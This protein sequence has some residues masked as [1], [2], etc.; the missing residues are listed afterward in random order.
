MVEMGFTV[1]C[2]A[3]LQGGLIP[4]IHAY[5]GKNTSPALQWSHTPPDTCSFVLIMED[6][7]AADGTVTH[8][9]LF[10]IPGAA[11]GLAEQEA[12]CGIPGRNDFQREGYTGPCPPPHGGAH[13]YVLRL[14]ALDVDSLGLPC[15][16]TRP[17]V[18]KAMH[19]HILAHTEIMGRYERR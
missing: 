15:G 2:P 18:E 7:D 5:D 8:W 3:F 1:T 6:P 9:M 12:S 10:D 13:R 19:D 14:Y 11:Q 17:D 4:A 16:A